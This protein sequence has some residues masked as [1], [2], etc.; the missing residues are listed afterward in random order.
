MNK[1]LVHRGEQGWL[2]T[3]VGPHAAQISDLFDTTTLPLPFTTQAPFALVL[4]T[5]RAK[6]PAGVTVEAA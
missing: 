2:A 3:Y 6:Q 5:L 4:A 1:I